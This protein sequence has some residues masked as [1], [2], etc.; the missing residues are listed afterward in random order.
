MRKQ[1]NLQGSA[2]KDFCVSWCCA[3]CALVQ[4]RKEVE[5]QNLLKSG[6][7]GAGGVAHQPTPQQGMSYGAPPQQQHQQQFTAQGTG[8]YGAQPVGQQ[9]GMAYG[10]PGKM[11]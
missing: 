6:A 2:G 11:Q 7:G 1:Y 8:A 4:E 10:E 9:Q 5:H 3:N